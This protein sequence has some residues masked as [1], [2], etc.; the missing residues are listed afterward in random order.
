MFDYSVRICTL[1]S[2]AIIGWVN[3]Y[4][5]HYSVM[6]L[7]LQFAEAYPGVIFIAVIQTYCLQITTAQLL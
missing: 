7:S 1:V 2:D 6:A 4:T 5:V 3:H